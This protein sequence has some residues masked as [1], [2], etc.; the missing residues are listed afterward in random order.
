MRRFCEH[1]GAESTGK[2]RSVQDHRRTFSLINKAYHHW[3][4][5]SDFHPVS[6]NHLRAYLLVKAGYFDVISIPVGHIRPDSP[7]MALVRAAVEATIAAAIRKGAYVFL[8]VSADAIETLW[9]K[10]ISFASLDQKAFGPLRE[11]IEEI[12]EAEIG[13]SIEELLTARAA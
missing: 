12:I 1:C 9:P 8:R 10:S 7:A 3:P 6:A 2:P 5:A 11:A 13:V 4:E